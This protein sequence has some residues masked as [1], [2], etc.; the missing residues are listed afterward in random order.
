MAVPTKLTR[1][2]P[3]AVHKITTCPGLFWC[4]LYGTESDCYL[5]VYFI[6]IKDKYNY[7]KLT[8]GN[9]ICL[10]ELDDPLPS[11]EDTKQSLFG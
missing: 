10:F 7:E 9:Q 3:E 6:F 2:S 1:V 5:L 11:S 8:V 4:W